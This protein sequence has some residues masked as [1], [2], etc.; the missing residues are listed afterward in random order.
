[1]PNFVTKNIDE[2]IVVAAGEFEAGA[3]C[4]IMHSTQR[5]RPADVMQQPAQVAEPGLSVQEMREL[6]CP[7]R[8]RQ[9]MAPKPARFAM[10]ALDA[11]HSALQ[12]QR[13]GNVGDVIETQPGNRVLQRCDRQRWTFGRR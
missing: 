6:A 12:G 5:D 11:Q 4:D 9:R 2:P 8:T 1:M 3:L 10:L 13:K 7:Q